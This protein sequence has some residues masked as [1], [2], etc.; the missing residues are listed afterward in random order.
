MHIFINDNFGHAQQSDLSLINQIVKNK[1][2]NMVQKMFWLI[3]KKQGSKN[4]RPNCLRK[5]VS[6]HDLFRF[7]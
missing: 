2:K 5:R 1:M 7:S 4:Y 3:K 6:F